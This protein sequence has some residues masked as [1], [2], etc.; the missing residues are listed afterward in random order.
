M[1]SEY[2]QGL[3]GKVFHLT[4][5]GLTAIPE[6][7]SKS[8]ICSQNGIKFIIYPT[9][10]EH[11]PHHVHVKMPDGKEYRIQTTD[12]KR[13]GGGSIPSNLQKIL[14]NKNIRNILSRETR[15]IYNHGLTNPIVPVNKRS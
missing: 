3:V 11:F 12:F 14:K 5:K 1:K 13:Y 9:P 4:D 15:K 10:D 8:K 2:H 6:N 7:S